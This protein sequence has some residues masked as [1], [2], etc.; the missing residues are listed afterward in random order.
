MSQ[1]AAEEVVLKD[2]FQDA[3]QASESHVAT[4]NNLPNEILREIFYHATMND[5]LPRRYHTV[6]A[7]DIQP[8]ARQW[9]TAMVESQVTAHAIS[10]ISHRFNENAKSFFF[11]EILLVRN[12][13]DIR[14]WA[15]K[16]DAHWALRS[17]WQVREAQRLGTYM[18]RLRDVLKQNPAYEKYCT[19]LCLVS[20]RV[21]VPPANEDDNGEV[22]GHGEIGSDDHGTQPESFDNGS[23]VTYPERS[24]LH[25]IYVLLNNVTDFQIHCDNTTGTPD[26]TVAL[27]LLPTINIIRVTGQVHYLSIFKQLSRHVPQDSSLQTLDLSEATCSTYEVEAWHRAAPYLRTFQASFQASSRKRR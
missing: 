16:S 8:D 9:K 27:S 25:D 3:Q 20:S 19:S 26:F 10:L 13:L 6:A 5:S 1:S 2:S 12:E 17:T 18:K 15:G 11:R 23:S 4:I 14:D 7:G 22:D 21:W 24:I